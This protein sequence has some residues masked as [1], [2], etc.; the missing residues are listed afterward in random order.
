[1]SNYRIYEKGDK[2]IMRDKK[3]YKAPLAQVTEFEC[4]DVITDSLAT[5][6]SGGKPDYNGAKSY[7]NIGGRNWSDIYKTN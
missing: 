5:S 7:V 2:K 1:M 3:E 4:A 6:V